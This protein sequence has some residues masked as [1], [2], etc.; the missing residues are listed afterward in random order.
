MQP[1]SSSVDWQIVTPSSSSALSAA[2]AVDQSVA[3]DAPPVT[4]AALSAAEQPQLYTA[5]PIHAAPY[6]TNPV[7]QTGTYAC[8]AD[9]PVSHAAPTTMADQP[10]GHAATP[11]DD[12]WQDA[13]PACSRSRSR[14]PTPQRSGRG[15]APVLPAQSSSWQDPRIGAGDQFPFSNWCEV[16]VGGDLGRIFVRNGDTVWGDDKGHQWIFHASSGAHPSSWQDMGRH[17]SS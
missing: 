1:A 2:A 8:N 3:Y 17:P 11:L 15:H 14:A 13:A 16:N 6:T 4:N 7:D 5:P 10:A 12:E 9:P